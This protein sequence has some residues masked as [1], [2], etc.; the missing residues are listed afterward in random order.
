MTAQQ[1]HSL[2]WGGMLVVFGTAALLDNLFQFG[3]WL[4]IGA[5]A[6][7]GLGSLF[8]Y[9]SDRSQSWP[10]IPTYGGL[11]LAAFIAAVDLELLIDPLIAPVIISLVGLPFIVVYLLDRSN[12]WALIP[13]Y[14]LFSVAFLVGIEEIGILGDAWVAPYVLTAVALPFLIV[15]LADRRQWWALIPAYILLAVGLM[16]ALISIGLLQDGLIATYVLFS[17]ALPF[18]IVFLVDRRQWWALIPAGINGLIGLSILLAEGSLLQYLVP[19]V[20]ILAG[21]ALIFRVFGGDSDGDPA[22]SMATDNLE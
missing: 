10:L 2:I 18:L 17:V 11:A 9:L 15:F 13:G 20:L 12:W 5:L 21:L 4:W 7:V 6:S 3:A 22:E 1:R 14:I 8:V 19:A 16:I